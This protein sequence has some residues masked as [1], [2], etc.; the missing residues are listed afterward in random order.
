VSVRQTFTLIAPAP[1]VTGL[2]SSVFRYSPIHT[3]RSKVCIGLIP[4]AHA[5]RSVLIFG[6]MYHTVHY[7]FGDNLYLPSLVEKNR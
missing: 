1:R 6:C 4:L 5:V 7:T 2:F 3:T